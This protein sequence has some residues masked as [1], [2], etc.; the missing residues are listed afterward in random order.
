[1]VDYCKEQFDKI[2]EDNKSLYKFIL[3]LF[4]FLLLEKGKR[5]EA[6]SSVSRYKMEGQSSMDFLNLT[7]EIGSPCEGFQRF[8]Y[9]FIT[10][11]FDVN[12]T[13]RRIFLQT[14]P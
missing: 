7:P 11:K 5:Y 10:C 4:L 14:S 8:F 3:E 1:M 12:L 13:R 6:R 2:V 9:I